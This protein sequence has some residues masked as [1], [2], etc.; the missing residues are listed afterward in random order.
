MPINVDTPEILV[1]RP[2]LVIG[3]HENLF[4]C[5]WRGVGSL[6]DMQTLNRVHLEVA[7]KRPGGKVAEFSITSTAMVAP[8][9]ADIRR[10]INR[11]ATELAPT[12][13][14]GAMVILGD[15]FGASI[16]R[17]VL[18]GAL[19]LRRSTFPYRSFSSLDDASTWLAPFVRMDVAKLEAMA[20]AFHRQL[21]P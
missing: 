14:A 5:G 10:E 19:L 8:V 17:S 3:S 7:A 2:A 12:Y 18:S 1:R 15:G 11:R 4:L 16:L 9:S 20:H 13:V 21:A 6:E